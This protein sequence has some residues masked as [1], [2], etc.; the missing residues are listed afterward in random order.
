MVAILLFGNGQG[1]FK[2][3]YKECLVSAPLFFSQ[4][5]AHEL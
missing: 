4:T 1:L 5:A 2:N 3:F